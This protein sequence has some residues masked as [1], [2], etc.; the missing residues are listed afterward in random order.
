MTGRQAPSLPA[1]ANGTSALEVARTC[2]RLARGITRA[3]AGRSLVSAT[4]GRGNVVTEA[5]ITVEQAVIR[6]LREQFPTHAILSEETAATTRSGDW[7]WV[8]DPID[9]TKNFSRGL[10]HF[11]FTLALCYG[12]VPLLGMT[13]HPLTGLEVIAVAGSGCFVDGAPARLREC[14]SIAEAV[15]AMDLGYDAERA[16]GQLALASRLWPGMQ[17]LRI[18]G[19]AA[20]GFA[21][22]AA[23]WWD[24][25]V[26]ADLQPWD[27]AAGLVIVREAGGVV[28]EPGGKQAALRSSAAVAG[29]EAV[30]ADLERLAASTSG[31]EDS[32]NRLQAQPWDS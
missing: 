10:P 7:M 32:A 18:P 6:L 2:A 29:T 15:F 1:A 11:A 28:L 13:T 4:K 31:G 21:G 8:I 14:S 3:S 16:R 27:I 12:E 23:G 22:L 30:V 26:H 17:S 9:G 20:L 25:Y 5:D 24:L 19:S